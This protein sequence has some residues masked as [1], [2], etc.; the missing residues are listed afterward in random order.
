MKKLLITSLAAITISAGAQTYQ[1]T[2]P[3]YLTVA[4]NSDTLATSTAV[5]TVPSISLTITATNS[6]TIV[7][8]TLFTGFTVGGTTYAARTFVYNAAVHGTNFTTNW[9]SYQI[10]VTNYLTGQA[11][12]QSGGTNTCYIK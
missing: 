4:T 10:T 9:P 5:V 11:S 1:F 2:Q 7:T 12:P 3:T 6:A 8:N